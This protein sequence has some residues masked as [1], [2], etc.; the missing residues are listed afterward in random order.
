MRSGKD[1][2]GVAMIVLCALAVLGFLAVPML[3]ETTRIGEDLCIE[4]KPIGRHHL[5]VIDQ[6]DP[7]PQAKIDELHRI[8]EQVLK[9]MRINDRVSIY[10]INA[11]SSPFAKD[12]P[13]ICNPGRG[14]DA[15]AYVQNPRL[16][17]EKFRKHFLRPLEEILKPDTFNQ[18]SVA[19]PLMEYFQDVARAQQYLPE[20]QEK[21]FYL[22][23]DFIQ[24][25]TLLNQYKEQPTFPEQAARE[26][27]AFHAPDYRGITI[28]LLFILRPEWEAV[29]NAGHKRF[30]QAYFKKYGA[31]EV[32][33]R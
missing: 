19:S 16:I 14:E 4:G 32:V 23:S 26:A 24:N 28:N 9:E 2:V 22:L 18:Q 29:Q 6:S 10:A 3:M 7:V 5:F 13:S 25:S 17:E 30:W 31:R 20:T 33:I 8:F 21:V 27:M 12:I 1:L 11:T 15:N